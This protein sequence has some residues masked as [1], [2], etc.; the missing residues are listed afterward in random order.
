MS[1]KLDKKSIPTVHGIRAVGALWI[2][3]GHVYYYAFGP[4][5]N[6]QLIFAYADSW[7]LQ[8]FFSAAISVDSFYV[9]R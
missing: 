1:T 2:F 5:E 3:A 4:T 7:I 8:P 6:L 9:M